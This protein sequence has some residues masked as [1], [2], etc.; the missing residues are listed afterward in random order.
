MARFEIICGTSLVSPELAAEDAERK[1]TAAGG[2][3]ISIASTVVFSGGVQDPDRALLDNIA[4]NIYQLVQCTCLTKFGETITR[5][6]VPPP[7]RG[8][9]PAAPGPS[10]MWNVFVLLKHAR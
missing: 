2:E 9:V 7:P 5:P 10:A 4:A 8:V 6:G 1:A 3:Q